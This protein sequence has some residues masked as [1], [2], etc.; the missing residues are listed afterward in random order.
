M[1]AKGKAFNDLKRLQDR[2]AK[3]RNRPTPSDEE[4]LS[5]LL[6]NIRSQWMLLEWQEL[7]QT[8]QK[9]LVERIEHNRQANR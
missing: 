5:D 2:L 3:N 8:E 4:L 7:L 6:T 9:I 1:S